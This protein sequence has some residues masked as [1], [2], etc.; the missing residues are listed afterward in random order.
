MP[1]AVI[2]LRG[3]RVDHAATSSKA[4]NDPF[5][6]VP[7]GS[8]KAAPVTQGGLF[9]STYIAGKATRYLARPSS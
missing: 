8:N 4:K 3:I 5:S 6:S 7:K 1:P 9:V 2:R